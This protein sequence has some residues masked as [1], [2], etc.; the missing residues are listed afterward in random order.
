MVFKAGGE[1]IGYYLDVGPFDV[2]DKI[3]NVESPDKKRKDKC[4]GFADGMVER[5]GI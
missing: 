4:V 5:Q 2:T 1:G 3:L